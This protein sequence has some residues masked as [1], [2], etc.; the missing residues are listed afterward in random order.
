MTSSNQSTTSQHPLRPYYQPRAQ[1]STSTQWQTTTTA[2]ATA[3]PTIQ[4][5]MAS[6]PS[7]SSSLLLRPA[8]PS[9]SS[10]SIITAYDLDL[11]TTASSSSSS[12]SLIFRGYLSAGMLAF[13]SA[14]MVMPFEVGKTLLQVQWI[15]LSDSDHPPH[16][17]DQED[18]L[19][20]AEEEEEEED[21]E[22]SLD[23]YFTQVKPTL[24][25]SIGST[26]SKRTISGSTTNTSKKKRG[27]KS[28]EMG[29]GGRERFPEWVLPVVVERGVTEMIRAIS[30]WRGEGFLGLWK[31]QL[32]AFVIDT[33]SA[34]VQPV[35]LSALSFFA[36]AANLS[37]S[38]TNLSTSLLPLEHY[39]YPGLP[40]ALAVGSYLATGLLLA[41]L[42]LIRTRLIVQ[43]SQLRHRTYSGPLD[44]L[45]KLLHDCRT[46][47]PGGGIKSLFLS[48]TLFFPAFLDNLLRPLFHLATPLFIDRYLN[49]DRSHDPVRFALAEF[50]LSSTAL[51]FLLPLETIRKRL[52]LQFPSS[53][54]AS[55]SSSSNLDDDHSGDSG[56]KAC[57]RLRPRPYNGI[58][59]AVYRIIVEEKSGLG[60]LFRGFNVGV[61]A[62]FLVFL[63]TVVGNHP[64]HHS[65]GTLFSSTGN[66]GSGGWAE[67]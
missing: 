62:N 50:A 44:G 40:L 66:G 45:K 59:D 46:K 19:D 30:R 42:D 3:R 48:P 54:P 23:A 32:T 27:R 38:T 31:G 51:L 64:T 12:L 9:P 5:L 15:P 22:E 7:S 36:S 26:I 57:V 2:T 17:P 41:P 49:L 1:H 63:L 24:R 6:S 53:S 43:S 16:V 28:N 61:T 10:S 56:F 37:T 25:P 34:K 47:H 52:Q 60:A 13:T 58:V 29:G 18:Y 4:D 65:A 39:A 11:R 55:S 20:E 21:D 67:V 14:A 35:F 33:A 8:H